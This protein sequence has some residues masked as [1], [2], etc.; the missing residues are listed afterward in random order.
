MTPPPYAIARCMLAVAAAAAVWPVASAAQM[1]PID[2]AAWSMPN[3]M[4]EGLRNGD[5]GRTR[6]VRD[7][8]ASA[9]RTCRSLPTFR[10]KLGASDPKIIRLTQ[11]CRKAGY[12]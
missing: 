9:I 5:R 2:P 1:T 10:R 11:L 3:V 8:E 6:S 4:V 12:R 7:R